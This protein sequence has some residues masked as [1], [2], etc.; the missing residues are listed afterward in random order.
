MPQGL[1]SLLYHQ[2]K[3]EFLGLSGHFSGE[4]A[5]ICLPVKA[6]QKFKG[7]LTE[8]NPKAAVNA[9]NRISS[10][11][12]TKIHLLEWPSPDFKSY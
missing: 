7:D 2:R 9:N 4:C 3:N 12:T 6:Q 5:A 10:T 8:Q 11:T 1:D